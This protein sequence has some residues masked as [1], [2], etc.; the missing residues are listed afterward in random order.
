MAPLQTART[1]TELMTDGSYIYA[2][3]GGDATFF[4]GVP[5][6]MSVEQYN[7]AT[8]TWT[9]GNPL[10]AKV[11]APSGGGVTGGKLMIMGGVDNTLYPTTVQVSQA[12]SVPCGSVTV[13]TTATAG[14]NTATVTSTV[15]AGSVTATPTS[16]AGASA[17][18]VTNGTGTIVPGTTDTGNH[19][20][21]CGTGITLPFPVT[22][23]GQTY[24][25]AQAGSNGYLS[26]D[27]AD[28]FFYSGCLPHTGSTYNIFPFATDQITGAAGKG[29]YTLTTGSTPN[30][31][32]YVEWRAC[33]YNGATTC[34]ANS[35][36]N[37]EIVFHEGQSAFSIVY[38][39]FG[40]ANAAVGAIGVQK[41]TT[42]FTQS[43]CN[44]GAPPSTQ[45]TYTLSCVA[46]VTVT[47]TPSITSTPAAT[48]TCPPQQQPITVGANPAAKHMAPVTRTHKGAANVA[49]SG[50]NGSHKAAPW[51]PLNPVSFM[52]DDGSY[53]TSVS[54]NNG[55]TQY[56]AVWINRFTPPA[57]SYPL[58]LQTIDIDWPLQASGSEIGLAVRLLVYQDTDGDGDPSNATLIGQQL[59][60]I[61]VEDSFQSYPVN[62]AVPGPTGDIYIGFEDAYAEAGFSPPFFPSP[63]DQGTSA[64]S[65]YVSGKST[66][67]PADINNLGNNDLTG[68]IDDLAPSL[69][70]NWLIR[71]TGNTGGGC[72]GTFT[73]T[74]TATTAPATSTATTA[75]ATS[76]ATAPADTAT[77]TGTSVS[78]TA[79][80]TGTS[81]SDTATVTSTSV[82][83]T[84][85]ATATSG[86]ATA[87]GVAAT[88]TATAAATRTATITPAPTDTPCTIHFT[89][90]TDPTAYYYQGVYYLACHGVISGYSDGTYRPF[91]NTTRGQMTKIV[92]LAFNIPLVTPPALDNRTFTDVT[93]DNVFYQLIETAAARQIVSGY[94]CGGVNSQTGAPEPCDSV[95]RPYFRPSNFVTRGQLTKIVVIGAAFPVINP[96][97]PTFN[98][99]PRTDVFY[100][101][102][103]TAVCHQIISGYNDGT[104]RPS[105]YAFRGQIAKIVYLAVTNPQATCPVGTPAV[106]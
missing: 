2:V 99:V 86:L 102:I 16:C 43:Q 34:L 88:H 83:D 103:E 104:F 68:V 30:R 37:Y 4:T 79:T 26:F 77:A 42:T 75:P 12:V 38:G 51:R 105:N 6:P 65:S 3:G 19:C 76:T 61:N 63:L 14:G 46:T 95:R 71:A 10:V 49:G 18:T 54:L 101:F 53:E 70:G 89:D 60:T 50:I 25:T 100:T 17:Y 59:G 21:D 15:M 67:A 90:V 39:A 23:Y 41:D 35:D 74:S 47:S 7:I 78:D 96:P 11:A 106:R 9:Y 20:D 48:A 13:T 24:T 92:T 91:N 36:S 80:A 52:L 27:T 64:H 44:A 85:T 66:N 82:S 33:R 57:A 28:D 94:T 84:A 32:F 72:P 58:T 62:I 81:V 31:T 1:A 69:A 22:L 45:Q 73:P 97:T 29:I 55:T 5:L 87:T 93:P 56:A 40:S 98:D 8:N